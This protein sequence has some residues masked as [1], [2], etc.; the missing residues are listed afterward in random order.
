MVVRQCPQVE[1]ILLIPSGGQMRDFCREC[2]RQNGV[3]PIEAEDGLEA[4]L[5]AASHERPVGLFITDIEKS[6]ISG[7][8]LAAMLQS[9]SPEIGLVFLSG[10][11][12]EKKR[13]AASQIR[14]LR[15]GCGV[16]ASQTA[17]VLVAYR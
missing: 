13:A 2:L 6:R 12:E 17:K 10:S 7:F 14:Q 15:K 3:Q 11:D 5:I 1:G 16:A 4:L 8:D 9:I